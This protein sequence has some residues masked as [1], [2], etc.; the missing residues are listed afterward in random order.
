M[1]EFTLIAECGGIAQLGCPTCLTKFVKAAYML[2]YE[3]IDSRIVISIE[4]P[5]CFLK[6][7]SYM[8]D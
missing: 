2:K 5:K 3:S 7:W 4:C 6:D 8:E 1:T